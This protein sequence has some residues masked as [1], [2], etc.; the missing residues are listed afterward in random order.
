MPRLKEAGDS[1][2]SAQEKGW[3]HTEA[4]TS[5]GAEKRREERGSRRAAA[6]KLRLF[7][8]SSSPRYTPFD[9]EKKR[10]VGLSG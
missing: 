6:T 8:H 3:F 2:L 10:N 1:E 7:L 9:S 5:A 4:L